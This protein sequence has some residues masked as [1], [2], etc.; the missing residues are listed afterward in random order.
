MHVES[1]TLAQAAGFKADLRCCTNKELISPL[2]N[3]LFQCINQ[4]KQ[5]MSN[6]S[7]SLHKV[8]FPP[9]EQHIQVINIIVLHDI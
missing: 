4:V 7:Y 8:T 2:H 6:E 5:I 9:N 1:V 3:D